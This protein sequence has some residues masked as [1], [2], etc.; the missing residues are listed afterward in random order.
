MLGTDAALVRFLPGTPIDAQRRHFAGWLVVML[1]AA[2]VLALLLWVAR[3][4]IAKLFFGGGSEYERFIPLAAATIWANV[5]VAGIRS[6]YRLR[7]DAWWFSAVTVGQAFF[8]LAA[9]I[10]ML[11]RGAGVYQLVIYLLLA[12]LCLAAILAATIA[13]RE[14]IVRPDYSWMGKLIR[15]G[16]PLVPAGFAVWGLNWMD[17]LFMVH[18]SSLQDIG[19]YSLA[20]ALG[21]LAI[22]VIANPIFAMFP[23][24]AA[25]NW[26]RG[27]PAGVQHLFE[28]TAGATVFL[29]VPAIAG[30][31]VLGPAIV[32]FLAPPS[33]SAAATVMPVIMVGYLFLMLAAYYEVSFGLVR[34]QWLS[35]A[36]VGVAVV[37]NVALNFLLIPPYSLYG[38]AAATS[39]AFAVQ[40]VFVLAVTG[41]LRTLRTPWG[42][43]TR[44]TLA[45]LLMAACVW[46]AGTAL[47][48]HGLL[49]LSALALAGAVLYVGLAIVVR[50]VPRSLVP[51]S[52]ADARA[53]LAAPG[54]ERGD[55]P[56]APADDR[57]G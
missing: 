56:T 37:V 5:L 4:P 21:Y 11:V 16:L 31:I 27:D 17:R 41:R 36:A 24:A 29:M 38:A 26:N 1:G 44:M 33:F 8:S 42:P 46:G 18:Y 39:G 55:A 12:D 48:T 25:A 52:V 47:G 50:A 20:Y 34:R 53:L 57:R 32:A 45:S 54:A 19:V 30:A 51:R 13:R 35:T 2:A 7:N 9:T 15:F 10:V 22:Q 23:T 28:R 3:E 43:P 49:R 40:L 6:W 14:G